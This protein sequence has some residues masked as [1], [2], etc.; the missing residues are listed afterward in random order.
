MEKKETKYVDGL[1]FNPKHP[2]QA[3]FVIGGLSF[4]KD[5]FIAWLEKQTPDERGY[6]KAQILEGKDKPYVVLDTWKP[7][8][9]VET[10]NDDLSDIAF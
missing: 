3:D 4:A 1:W 2:K 9:K 8:K 6:V 5:K 7:T 10:S